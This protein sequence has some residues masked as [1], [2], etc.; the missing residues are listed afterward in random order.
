MKILNIVNSFIILYFEYIKRFKINMS[1]YFKPNLE[2]SD[3]KGGLKLL[4]DKLKNK[5]NIINSLNYNNTDVEI[6][7]LINFM[8]NCINNG[9]N[10]VPPGF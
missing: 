5:K 9:L 3:L 2:Y 8:N 6:K 10:D 1:F 4:K 7:N